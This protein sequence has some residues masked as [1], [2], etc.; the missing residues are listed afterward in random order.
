MDMAL[1]DGSEGVSIEFYVEDS[2]D[3]VKRLS[4]AYDEGDR[5]VSKVRPLTDVDFM[6]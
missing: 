6:L 5:T 1:S 3:I 4:C 2:G